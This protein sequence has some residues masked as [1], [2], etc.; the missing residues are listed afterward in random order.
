MSFFVRKGDARR[1]TNKFPASL[2]DA[3]M[4]LPA[5]NSALRR[6][7]EQWFDEQDILPIVVGEFDDSAL[8]KAFGESG[9]GVFIGPSAIEEEICAMYHSSVV[10]RTT[11]ITERYYAISSERRL[12]HPAVVLITETARSD[13]FDID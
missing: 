8:L 7:L 5:R 9:L 2:N 3:P 13:L 11:D 1:Y 10:G 6:R 12:E 4:L